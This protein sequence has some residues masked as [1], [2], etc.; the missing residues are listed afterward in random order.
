MIEIQRMVQIAMVGA[1][2]LAFAPLA[3]IE[4]G[5]AEDVGTESGE[6]PCVP[7]QSVA[8]VCGDGQSGAQVCEPD[9]SGFG[10]CSCAGGDGDGDT[11]SGDGDGDTTSGDGDGDTT[12]GDG[13]TTSGDGD[14]DPGEWDGESLPSWE[15]HVVPFFYETCGAGLM[16]CHRREAYGAAVDSDCRGWLSLEDVPLGSVFYSGPDEGQPTECPDT[17]LYDRLMMAPW[18]C[19]PDTAY[20]TP[21]DLQASYLW[22]KI[23][24]QGLCDLAPNEPS[25]PMPPPDSGIVISDMDK[26]M[27]EA[28]ILGGAPNDN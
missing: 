14:G 15:N 1:G 9:G 24:G 5:A 26:A 17:P 21:G 23:Q 28:W 6:E 18:Q 25:S 10:E 4:D 8:C 12:S 27:I 3:C 20:V 2:L 13:D 22:R 7:G 11:T 19:A 16:G